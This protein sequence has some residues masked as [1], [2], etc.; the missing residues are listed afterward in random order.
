MNS[1]TLDQLRLVDRIRKV[2]SRGPLFWFT[3]QEIIREL[4][5]EYGELV[6]DSSVTARCR[7]LRKPEFG[8]FTVNSRKRS[9]SRA[10]EYQLV[11]VEQSKAA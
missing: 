11:E 1:L 2:I 3:P 7:D 6:S 9:G 8:S 10:W 5:A 4:L